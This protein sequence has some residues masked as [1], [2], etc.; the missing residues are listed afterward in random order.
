MP[1]CILVPLLACAA[2]PQT[3]PPPPAP[4]AQAREIIQSALADKNPDTRKLAATALSLGGPHDPFLTEV[5]RLMN[6][7]DVEVRLAAISSLGE[8]KTKSSLA[9]L[10][11]ALNDEVPEVSFAAARALYNANDPA[12]K[13][14]LLA[15]LAGDA[16]VASGFIT[17]QKRD[18]L[19]M[20][21]TPRTTLM[22]G[23][24]QG[25]G[26]VP[27]PGLGEGVSSLQ[28][29]LTDPGV[30]GRAM[31]ALLLGKEKDAE[32]MSALR[33]ALDDKDWSVR[34]AAVHALAL[35]N[36]PSVEKDLVPLFD[37]KHQG[38]RLRAAAGYLRLEWV[39]KPARAA[40]K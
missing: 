5:E 22:F 23:L 40:R 31:A 8:W 11:T 26:F 28:G 7:K 2:W 4:E 37:D 33:D 30:S 36:D 29:L 16:K 14:L 1:R 9:V 3:A 34:A 27:V 20:L 32:T 38:V 35:R 18:A 15:V 12:G 17:K 39:R 25:V 24:K 13:A 19:R 6:D 21:H 10:R